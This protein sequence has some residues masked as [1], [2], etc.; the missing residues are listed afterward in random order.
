MDLL[1]NKVS[2]W[3]DS[4]VVLV[5]LHMHAISSSNYIHFAFIKKC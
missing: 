1:V 2:A 5:L 4:G 3:E